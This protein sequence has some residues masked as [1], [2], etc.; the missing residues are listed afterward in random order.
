MTEEQWLECRE[1]TAMLEVLHGKASE[2]KVRLFSVACCRR[3]WELLSDERSRQAID[4]AERYADAKT[5]EGELENAAD[6]ACAVCDADG[7]AGS[8]QSGAP[9][10]P[11]RRIASLAAYNVALPLGWWGAA[12]AFVAPYEIAREVVPNSAAEAAAQC[13]LVRDI[14][15]NPFRSVSIDATWRTSKVVVLAQ[16]IYD[17]RAFDRLPALADALAEGGCTDDDIL[18]HCRGPGPHVKG[19]WALDLILGKE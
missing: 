13:G 8:K 6:A 10:D 1:P 9:D 4:I 11:F 5:T 2:R 14:F 19:C 17:N 15:G 12:P 16:E 18:A 3:L 7:D